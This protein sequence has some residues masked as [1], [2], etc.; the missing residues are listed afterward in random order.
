MTD[1]PAK[2]RKPTRRSRDIA[3]GVASGVFAAAM[4]GAAYAAVPLYNWICSVTGM[5]GTTQVA[6]SAPSQT[7]ERTITVRFDGNVGPG[8]PWQFAPEKNEVEVKIGEVVTVY[9][10][11]TN[12]SAR[13]TVGQ[14]AYN[15]APMTTGLYFQKINCFCFTEQRLAPGEKREMAVVFYVDPAIANDSENDST[16][17]IILSYT[18]F[19]VK[20]PLPQPLAAREDKRAGR[21]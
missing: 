4:V 12:Q 1:Q 6:T 8:L 7:L 3:V 10:T 20:D 9:Y 15:V 17:T 16:K 14:A 5:N 2:I 11:V 13:T 21:L 18:F 19:P